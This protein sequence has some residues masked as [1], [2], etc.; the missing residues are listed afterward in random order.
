[1]VDHT[2]VLI[3]AGIF[4]G[5]FLGRAVLTVAY[6]RSA[7]EPAQAARW[8]ELFEAGVVL[9][10]AAWGASAWLLFPTQ[11]VE[12]QAFIAVLVAG[13][14][15]G[16]LSSLSAVFSA[17]IAFLAF[18][19][20]PVAASF[21]L[22]DSGM[23][24]TLGILLMVFFVIVSVGARRINAN[25]VQNLTLRLESD[26][27][28]KTLAESEEKYRRLFELSKD[29]MCLIV[30]RRPIMA[31]EAASRLLGYESPQHLISTPPSQL[32]PEFQ[33]DGRPSR[34][35]ADEMTE[36]AFRDGYHR[37]EWMHLRKNGETIPVE[38]ALTR[39]PFQ[40]G[41]ALFCVLRDITKR[42][43]AER[44]LIEAREQ[45]ESASKA[46]SE[47]LAIMSHEI[48]TPMN[49]V[50]GMAELL[51]DTDLEQEQ[52]EFADTIYQ[53]GR[54]LLG[55]IDNILDFSKIE[56]G[57]LEL[58]R[59]PFDLEH[60]VREVAQLLAER[61]RERN[62]ALLVEYQPG[63]PRV[64]VGDAGRIRQ[65][66]LNLVGNALKFTERGEVVVKVLCSDIRPERA[67]ARLLVQDSGIGIPPEQKE[68]LFESFTQADSSTTR[69][70]GGT[71]LGL[72]I[73]KQLVEMMDGEIGVESKPG[74]G[75]VFWFAL[76]L[77]RGK[78]A[79]PVAAIELNGLRLLTVD[80][81]PVNRQLIHLQLEGTGIRLREASSAKE[82][83]EL[84]RKAQTG[85]TP[86]N[87]ALVDRSM[88]ERDGIALTRMIGADPQ[89]S[90][91]P[92]IMMTSSGDCGEFEKGRS[93]GISAC[94]SKPLSRDTLRQ[95]I[96]SVL[97]A[98]KRET[99]AKLSRPVKGT[100]IPPSA[101]AGR[102][103]VA[104]DV[105][106]NQ[107]VVESMLRRLGI[108]VEV[109]ADGNEVV[110]AYARQDFDLILMDC[111][112]PEMDGFEATRQIR[113]AEKESGTQTPIIALTANA[114][115]AY[116][117]KCLD[118]GMDDF[119]A[120]PFEMQT[121]EQML[122]RWLPGQGVP[123]SPPP[124]PTVAAK[125]EEQPG[126]SVVDLKTLSVLRSVLGDDFDQ[127][128]P[129]YLVNIEEMLAKL[130]SAYE[131][132]NL[133]EVERYAHSVKSAS[134]NLG[135]RHLAKMSEELEDQAHYNS[136]ADVPQ[137][138]ATMQK[139]F[140]K[141]QAILERF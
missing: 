129:A 87:I 1:V 90:G 105:P 92:V 72:A 124:Q 76:T 37:F 64:F 73:S 82:A 106:A 19:L 118:A 40:G 86:F 13:L 70:Y 83:M 68:Q 3:W 25:I 114:T 55:I 111:Q 117:R 66:L 34:E 138:V 53:S 59:G 24:V 9:S 26:A 30:G 126:D 96:T 15:A 81:N 65:I 110:A 101:M 115:E 46:K 132:K 139:E 112:M 78:A 5:I 98:R 141:V 85:G 93:A 31:N 103:L 107:K 113:E 48:R 120:K 74:R 128:I 116:R 17:F 56:A 4:F 136:F 121:L 8:R 32:S 23:I 43:R 22:S 14:A 80:D 125:K 133:T 104:E 135:A 18:T 62:L 47:F 33:E 12:H 100:S 39:I 79:Q 63:C 99:D 28:E 49:A 130:P 2:W 10:G 137:Q 35:Q 67:T 89:L 44:A 69:R 6:F 109:A 11:S 102:V 97:T 7:P 20:L 51:Q 94:L 57:R 71:G 41:D 36:I 61:A 21:L 88:P 119:I 50:L 131:R 91:L 60:L 75:T 95:S 140:K 29:P 52:Q 84:L 42:K 54:S 38:S 123:P 58:S 127:L 108:E 16:A 77:P 27:R 122:L 45:A 134:Q